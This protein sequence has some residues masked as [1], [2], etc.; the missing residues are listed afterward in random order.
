[1]VGIYIHVPF[2]KRKCP[3]CSF[4]SVEYDKELCEAY[5]CALKRNIEKYKD[6]AIF[7]DTIYFGGGTP[8]L[9]SPLQINSILYSIRQSFVLS[10]DTEITMEANPSSVDFDKL[11]SFRNVGVN[12]I[13]FGVQSACDSELSALGRLHDYEMAQNAVTNAQNAGFRNISCDLMIG[14]PRQTMESLMGSVRKIAC[15]PINH[16]SAYMLKIEEGTM[17][18]CDW[19]RDNV[20]DEDEVCDMYENLISLLKTYGFNQYEISN[21]S[22]PNCHSRHNTKYWTGESYLGFGPSA[23]SYFNKKRYFVPNDV[24]EFVANDFQE[25]IVT[26]ENPDKVEEYIMLSLRLNSGISFLK[27]LELGG[28]P[29]KIYEK[30]QIFKNSDLMEISHEGL[31]LTPKGFLVS[32]S[33]ISHLL[34]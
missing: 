31:K 33:I 19:V 13:S 9:L 18:D 3:Y 12:R 23:H 27:I 28:S 16:I 14:T 5:V 20:A 25:E 30:A 34:S 4:Y 21:F 2:C 6:E 8:S 29:E 11:C 22:K 1:M 32:N 17:F 26:E 24:Y 15:L 7:V 10:P